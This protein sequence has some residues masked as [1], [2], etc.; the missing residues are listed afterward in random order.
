MPFL[1]PRQQRQSTEGK[2][3]SISADQNPQ[4]QQ[5]RQEQ[6]NNVSYEF[7]LCEPWLTNMLSYVVCFH[8]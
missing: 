5:K 3:S 6:Y 4:Q 2:K 1:P 7:L 8:I